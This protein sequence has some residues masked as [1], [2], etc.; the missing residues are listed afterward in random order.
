[1]KTAVTLLPLPGTAATLLNDG[2]SFRYASGTPGAGEGMMPSAVAAV[3]PAG[4]AALPA[5][6]VA[7]GMGAVVALVPPFA[8]GAVVTGVVGR[9]ADGA[10]VLVAVPPQA[11]RS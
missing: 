1:M 2:G 6:V 9:A 11:V 8:V 10:G 4:A 7:L 5:A 3:V